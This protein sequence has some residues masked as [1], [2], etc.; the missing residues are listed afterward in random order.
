MILDIVNLFYKLSKEHKLVKGFK[1]DRISKGMGVGDEYH[2]LVFLEDP[3]FLNI[4][5][6]RNGVI[7]ATI[8]FNVVV[9]P[10]KGENLNKYPKVEFLQ[11]LCEDIAL[12]FIA[13]IRDMI[14]EDEADGIESVVSWN[15]LT[16]RHWSDNDACGV[17][18]TLVL[19][20]KNEINFCDL[21][22][23][24]DPEKEF[25]FD[26]YLPIYNTDDAIGCAVFNDKTKLPDFKL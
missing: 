6:L 2:P 22:E 3:I 1:Y 9:T 11:S 12:N 26:Q 10:Q 14:K 16:L 17:R 25:D 15:I 21:D 19:N 5:S 20:V 24:F 8:N 13:K 23:H 7:P 4:A 18:V